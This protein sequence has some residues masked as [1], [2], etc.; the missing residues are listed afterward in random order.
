MHIIKLWSC[1][2]SCS[3]YS[4]VS[5]DS[6]VGVTT[7]PA[8]TRD[9]TASLLSLSP[10]RSAFQWVSGVFPGGEVA[11]VCVTLR[12]LIHAFMTRINTVKNSCN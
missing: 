11:G 2:T 6:T 8:E 5:C 12:P 4:A 3:R 9:L 10:V 1:F 7:F